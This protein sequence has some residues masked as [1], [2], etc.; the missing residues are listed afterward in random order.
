MSMPEAAMNKNNRVVF[1]QYKVGFAGEFFMVQAVAE[2]MCMQKLTHQHF[3]FCV[4][5]FNAA[6]IVTAGCYA[7]YIGHAAKLQRATAAD[8][9]LPTNKV[10]KA[11]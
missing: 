2:T 8:P 6:H 3:R 5:A 9:L 1:A 7:V 11:Q 10:D 4:L